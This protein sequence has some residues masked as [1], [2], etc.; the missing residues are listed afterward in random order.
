MNETVTYIGSG[1]ITLVSSFVVDVNDY[2][3][4]I[5]RTKNRYKIQLFVIIYARNLVWIGKKR[6]PGYMQGE[7][8][9]RGVSRRQL[10]TENEPEME[11]KEL[12]VFLFLVLWFCL[13]GS[14]EQRKL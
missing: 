14:M 6:E 8:K 2:G 4:G 10:E 5:S 1:P 9:G 7:R 3:S 11:L 12:I 13:W